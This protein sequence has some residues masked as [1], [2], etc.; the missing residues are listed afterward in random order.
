MTVF[1]HF[2]LNLRLQ[3]RVVANH[4]VI[5]F[6]YIVRHNGKLLIKFLMDF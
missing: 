2:R 5:D 4:M 3:I 6:G 1:F